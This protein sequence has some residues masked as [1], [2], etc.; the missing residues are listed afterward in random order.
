MSKVSWLVTRKSP[1]DREWA[2]RVNTSHALRD[3]E[4]GFTTKISSDY[5]S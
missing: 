2:K 3:F 4:D 1:H 5:L